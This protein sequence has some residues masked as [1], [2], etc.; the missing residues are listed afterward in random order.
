M[1]FKDMVEASKRMVEA[2]SSVWLAFL[3]AF[4]LFMLSLLISATYIVKLLPSLES[5]VLITTL[6]L[7]VLL[8][9]FTLYHANKKDK[10]FKK[11]YITSSLVILVMIT[12]N[13]F[14]LY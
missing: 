11:W 7:Y 10:T 12:L 4:G 3:P 6:V 5:H 2:I 8:S 14:R 13:L 1:K 9:V